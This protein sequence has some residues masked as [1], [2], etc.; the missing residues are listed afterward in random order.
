MMC[1]RCEKEMERFQIQARE[2][3]GFP[4]GYYLFNRCG[5]CGDIAGDYA[6]LAVPW[7]SA[8]FA[9]YDAKILRRLFA[10]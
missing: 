8:P 5:N 10:F 3:D 9:K 6:L 4:E 2:G 7:K 1:L